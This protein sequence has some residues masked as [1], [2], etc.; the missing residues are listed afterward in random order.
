MWPLKKKKKPVRKG[1]KKADVSSHAARRPATGRT[2]KSAR[3]KSA[4][5]RNRRTGNKRSA[6]YKDLRRRIL[7]WRDRFS[8]ARSWLQVGAL[9]V[10]VLVVYVGWAGGTFSRFG[11][12]TSQQVERSVVAVGLSIRQVRVEGRNK[13][14]LEAVR[15]AIAIEPG[16]SILHYDLESARARLERLDWVDEA[17]VIRFL[18]KTIHVVLIERSPVALWQFEQKHY[19]IDRTGFV[20]GAYRG[21]GYFDLPLLVGAGAAEHSAELLNVLER[22]EKVSD[23]IVASIRVGDRRWNLR[24]SNG[25][26]IQLPA[27][28]METALDRVIDW[29]EEYGVLSGPYAENVRAIDFRLG[30]RAFFRMK[31]ETG[32]HLRSVDTDT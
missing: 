3:S 21:E 22:R 12:W 28:G 24:L 8:E 25:M 15:T 27:E 20:I 16:S 7:G 17:Q 1:R 29:D 18:P 2:S 6:Q 11:D 4:S 10:T 13:T 26:E 23:L 19:L 14:D 32:D 31:D 9:V 5:A 30:D